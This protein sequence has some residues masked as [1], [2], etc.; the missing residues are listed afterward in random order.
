MFKNF[1]FTIVYISTLGLFINFCCNK[2]KNL[3]PSLEPSLNTLN[4]DGG[5]CSTVETINESE[6]CTRENC[7]PNYPNSK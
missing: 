4:S 6:T 7:N 3:S 1:L 2:K 5:N